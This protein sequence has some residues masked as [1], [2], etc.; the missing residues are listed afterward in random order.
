MDVGGVGSSHI[1][2]L[3]EQLWTE[4]LAQKP[5]CWELRDARAAAACDHSLAT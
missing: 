1:H 3:E 5:G 4:G 2:G